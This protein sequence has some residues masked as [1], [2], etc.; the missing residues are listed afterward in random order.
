[1]THGR[2]RQRSWQA[3]PSGAKGAKEELGPDGWRLGDEGPST[4]ALLSP[5]GGAGGLSLSASV[6]PLLD[7]CCVTLHP[8]RGPFLVVEASLGFQKESSLVVLLSK[9][10]AGAAGCGSRSLS[11]HRHPFQG[12]PGRLVVCKDPAL[13]EPWSASGLRSCRTPLAGG[14]VPSTRFSDAGEGSKQ[15]AW[16]GEAVAQALAGSPVEEVAPEPRS[17][18][19]RP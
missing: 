17:F 16:R 9:S 15:Q 14:T 1:M 12:G 10:C 5:G 3:G 19:G 13:R 18:R 8:P 11:C 4:G 6:Q 2:C 7:W